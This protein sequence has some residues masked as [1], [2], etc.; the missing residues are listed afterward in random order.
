MKQLTVILCLFLASCATA[1]GP[2]RVDIISLKNLLMVCESD[3]KQAGKVI[4]ERDLVKHLAHLQRMD[5]GGSKYYLLEREGITAM[6]QSV[7]E[8]VYADFILVSEDGRVIYAMTDNGLFARNVRSTRGAEA[9][10]A[11]HARREPGPFIVTVP[12]LPARQGASF[13][14]VSSPVSS[15][16]TMPGT[17][18][19]LVDMEKIRKLVGENSCIIGQKGVYEA[20]CC[21]GEI[22]TPYA[23]FNRIDLSGSGDGLAARRFARSSGKSAEYRLFKYANLFWILVT[24]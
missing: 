2:G 9:L 14:A 10:A 24:E 12:S 8:G 4:V 3:L 5:D 23:D 11:C 22:N 6:I 19:L 21:G 7:T 18:I 13:L 16:D 20:A 1:P 17:F 15:D